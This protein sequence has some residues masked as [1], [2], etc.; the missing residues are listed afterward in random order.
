MPEKNHIIV[1]QDRLGHKIGTHV[2][3]DVMKGQGGGY[4]DLIV[5]GSRVSCFVG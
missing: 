5:S 2:I 3:K 4:A 1:K